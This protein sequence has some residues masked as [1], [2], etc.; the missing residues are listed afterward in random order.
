M[1]QRSSVAG[2][3]ADLV[4]SFKE[5]IIQAEPMEVEAIADEEI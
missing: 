5:S 1:E 3:N 4:D 2:Q